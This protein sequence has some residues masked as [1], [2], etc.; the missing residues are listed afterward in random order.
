M[1]LK[2]QNRLSFWFVVN[3]TIEAQCDAVTAVARRCFIFNELSE[4]VMETAR[5]DL[6]LLYKECLLEKKLEGR[7]AIFAIRHEK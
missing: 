1:P 5:Q 6:L 3:K 2:A 4:H 7:K